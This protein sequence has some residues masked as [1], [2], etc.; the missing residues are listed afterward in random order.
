MSSKEISVSQ[1]N[2][3]GIRWIEGVPYWSHGMEPTTNSNVASIVCS[4]AKPSNG[5]TCANPCGKNTQ[6][7][8]D[9]WEKRRSLENKLGMSLGKV[10]G[11]D[12]FPE[13]EGIESR[14]PE[15]FN[16]EDE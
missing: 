11:E 15:F 14:Y 6:G 16:R 13:Q 12:T 3:C 4:R 8:T 5:K 2:L 10:L 1:C 9:S 7:A